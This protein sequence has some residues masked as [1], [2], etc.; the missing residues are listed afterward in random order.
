[1]LTDEQDHAITP[2]L[3]LWQR[4]TTFLFEPHPDV[5]AM[6][7]RTQ[8]RLV[9][10]ITFL[11]VLA[12]LAGAVSTFFVT[13]ISRSFFSL[14]ALT[15]ISMIGYAL[16]R[17]IRYRIGGYTIVWALAF[18]AFGVGS[19]SELSQSL[20]SNLI[21]AVVLASI[22]FPLRHMTIFVILNTFAIGA[23][24]F[25]YR[26]Y[27][28]VG[29]DLGVFI[30]FCLLLL[31]AMRHRN[32]LEQDHLT[33]LQQVNHDLSTLSNDL[34]QRVQ[35]RT[36]E[37]EKSSLQSSRR[38]LQ[39]EAIAEVASSVA[40]IQ[41]LEQ[42]L[43]YITQT[44][45]QRFGF[46]HAGIFL[47][48]DDKQYAVL[49][50]ANSEGGRKMLARKHQ[51]QVGQEGIVGFSVA[52]KQAHIALDV[53]EDAVFFNNPDLPS[54]HSEMALPLIIGKDVIGVLDVQSEEKNAFSNED[55]EVLSILANQVAVAIENAR[56]YEQSKNALRELDKTLQRYLSNE[57][58]Q[59]AT[60]SKV[61]GYRALDTGL[62]PLMDTKEDNASLN[63]NKA[64]QNIPIML[65]GINL[66]MLSVDMGE[67]AQAYN[68]EETNLIKTVADRLA[69][70]LESARL[71][72]DSQQ[73]AAKEQAIGEI[74]GKI[75]SSINLRNVLQ[76]AVEELGR[77]I[78]GS[79][80]LIQLNP[81]VESEVR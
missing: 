64:I 17:T 3:S 50:A 67:H 48:S 53:G 7:E 80:V 56:L 44:V 76:T 30:P 2:S 12:T 62:I 59:F 5:T 13:G 1:M 77:A 54:T 35:E 14:I 46:Y 71:L 25:F 21:L 51:L 63:K 72:E 11:M 4:L 20:Y 69:L 58:K 26:G 74:T 40:S 55:V 24:P 78:P 38:A 39:L 68:E 61:I 33:E 75:G 10:T 15:F 70:A 65:R 52:E 60:R 29:T 18:N 49:R 47:L 81:K 31:A 41:D 6:A 34:D 57:W 8:A 16:S 28:N 36:A 45:S 22:I 37:L 42:V 19:V 79:E 27:S 23:A 66:G 43:P 9:S 32:N 73:A